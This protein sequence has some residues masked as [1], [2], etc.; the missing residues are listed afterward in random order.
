MT[1]SRGKKQVVKKMI[2]CCM[3]MG[4]KRGP[5]TAEEDEILVSFIKKEGEGRWRSLPK[6]AGLLRC[7]KSCRL[8]WMNYLRPSVKR[9]G[10]T[11]DEEDLI[12]RLHRLLGNR[13]SLIAG[14]IPGR[15][16]NEIKNYWNTH[17]RKKLLSEGIDPQTHKPLDAKN[18]HHKP[19]EEV[20]GGQ[21]LLE[22]N[23][24]SHTDDTTVNSGNEATKITFSVFGGEDNEDFGFCYDDKFSSFLNAL[25]NDDP[26][27]SNI[28]LS[29]P[30]R[31]QD[32]TG[33]IVGTSSSLE[34]GQRIED[35]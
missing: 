35:I 18:A 28:P 23:S 29:Q 16:D 19:G 6:R 4:M 31:T 33:E 32:C 22:P 3:K 1:S 17:L 11:P 13:W 9:G 20:S 12:I 5:W 24:S 26:F 30:F 10:I 21:N 7:G 25:I 14:R 15:T 8:R 2:P 27:D 34:H